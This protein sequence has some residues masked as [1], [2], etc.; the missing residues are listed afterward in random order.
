MTELTKKQATALCESRFWETMSY[1]ERTKFQMIQER[2]CMPFEVFHEAITKYLDRPVY[3]HEFGLNRDGLM[4]E[5]FKGAPPPT[6]EEIINFI[7]AEKRMV[8][9]I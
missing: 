7:P 2:L 8:I 6:I 4:K 5:V 3:T 1:E 9:I